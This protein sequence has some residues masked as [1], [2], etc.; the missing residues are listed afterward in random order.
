M[1]FEEYD[2]DRP[3]IISAV[4]LPEIAP[5]A[6]ALVRPDKRVIVEKYGPTTLG[7]G[8][9]IDVISIREEG[10]LESIEIVVDNPYVAVMLEMDEYRNSDTDIGETPAEMIVNKRTTRV[11]GRFYVSDKADDGSYTLSY[12][13]NT[14]EKYEHK[15][16]LRLA[17]MIRPSSDVFGVGLN[18]QGRQGLPT[19]LTAGH[20]A[21][22]TFVHNGLKEVSLSTMASAIARPIGSSVYEAT[23]VFNQYV[24]DASN[25][26]LGS[27][28]PYQGIAGKPKFTAS[29]TVGYLRVANVGA[30]I[31]DE[32]SVSPAAPAFTGNF[33][34]YLGTGS[35]QQIAIFHT[36]AKNFDAPHASAGSVPL[37]GFSVGDRMFIRNKGTMYFPGK[38]TK[39]QYYQTQDNQFE[40]SEVS[41]DANEG[42]YVL[43]CSP[44]LQSA[45]SDITVAADTN[46]TI[47]IGT[48]TTNADTSPPVLIKNVVVKRR[49]LTSF[50]G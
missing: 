41:T 16:R 25:L 28:H 18:Y 10:Y 17:N 5:S 24:Y 37:S 22:G 44:G 13:P 38:I 45:P 46:N 50:D 21:G 23:N 29:S 15:F 2:D 39:I 32:S 19:P 26:T 4:G 12:T 8:E 47:S 3:S 6:N 35:E 34:G 1:V 31:A 43:T 27:G 14:P 42:G 11:D 9:T 7:S 33:P 36:S 49:K 30:T 48:L 40:N 20:V